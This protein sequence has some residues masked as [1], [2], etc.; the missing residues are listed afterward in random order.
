MSFVVVNADVYG[1]GDR[2]GDVRDLCVGM[3]SSVPIALVPHDEPGGASDPRELAH[4]LMPV[5]DGDCG[6]SLHAAAPAALVRIATQRANVARTWVV[7]ELSEAAVVACQVFDEVWVATEAERVQL[8]VAGVDLERVIVVPT[9]LDLTRWA[10]APCGSGPLTFLTMSSD[11]Q[12]AGAASVLEAF[13]TEFRRRDRVRLVVVLTDTFDREAQQV[14]ADLRRFA[15]SL[16]RDAAVLPDITVVHGCPDAPTLRE[17]YLEAH[18]YVRAPTVSELG[19]D[20][21]QAMALGL[22]VVSTAPGGLA[23]LVTADRAL[24]VPLRQT[25][26]PDLRRLRG[27]LRSLVRPGSTQ[28]RVNAAREHVQAH[29]DRVAIAQVASRRL[30]ALLAGTYVS[31]APLLAAADGDRLTLALADDDPFEVEWRGVFWNPSGYATEAHSFVAGLTALGRPIAARRVSRVELGYREAMNPELRQVLDTALARRPGRPPSVSIINAPGYALHRRSAP[32]YA[33]GRTMFETDGLCPIWVERCNAMDEI[34]VPTDF[35]AHTFRAAGVTTR[36]TVIPDGVDAER[37]RPGLEPLALPEV[38]GKV[39]LGIFQWSAYK[40]WDVLLRAWYAAFRGG[41]EATLVLRT[42]V[43]GVEP[44]ASRRQI[45][46]DIEAFARTE[47]GLRARDL[48]RIVLLT[49]TLTE[50]ELPRLYAAADALVAPSR[51]EGWGLPQIE[52]LASGLPVLATA[53]GGT[54]Q[55]LHPGNSVPVAVDRLVPTGQTAPWYVG[56]KWAE[57]SESSLTD[58]LRKVVDAPQELAALAATGRR[59]IEQRWTWA[60]SVARVDERL[61][62]IE[63]E[64]RS[65]VRP[66]SKGIPVRWEGRLFAHHSLAN[67]NRELVGRLVA[68]PDLD[69][70][71]VVQEQPQQAPT[72]TSFLRSTLPSSLDPAVTV[73]HQWPPDLTPVPT[74]KLVLVQPWEYGGLPDDWVSALTTHVDEAWVYT[75]WL[76][77]CYVRSGVPAEKVHLVPLG[78]DAELFNPAGPTYPLETKATVRLLYVGGLIPRKGTD[79]LLRAFTEEFGADDDVALVVKCFGATTVYAGSPLLTLTRAAATD[80]NGPEVVLVEDDLSPS[81][82]AAL[83]RSCDVLVHP[84]RGEGYGLTIAEGMASGLPVVTTAYGA[85]LDFC[86]ADEALLVPA[87]EVPLPQPHTLPPS[88]TGY[89]WAEP[90]LGA[91]RDALRQMATDVA[92][93]ERLGAAG[94]RAACERLSWDHSAA[95]AAARLRTIAAPERTVFVHDLDLTDARSLEVVARYA[96]SFGPE[97]PTTL[98]LQAPGLS[99]SELDRAAEILQ[100]V[101]ATGTR[102]E[103]DVVLLTHALDPADVASLRVWRVPAQRTGAPDELSDLS[104][105]GW[106][107][108]A[109]LA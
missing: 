13:V 62:E 54:T 32:A 57:P 43:Q 94:R 71:L 16:V 89:W 26:E 58:A 98:V 91:L 101:L 65:R 46:Q 78:V 87:R 8:G 53:W 77:D 31:P 9:G 85:A 20:L 40:G 92:L 18:A 83:Y 81:Q 44:R 5:Q 75:S 88:R 11:A 103:P 60:H 59:E 34:W 42:Y 105:A 69:L 36:I 68:D 104:A 41:D 30:E 4:L 25:G 24:V 97:D 70:D 66:V 35:N 33:I 95:A 6:V 76:R 74:G 2:A 50:A 96:E 67:A 10:P 19:R 15:R 72:A 86:T 12:A 73:R 90:D 39:V 22:P 37:F 55:F 1:G 21:L 17:L 100:G 48:G 63:Q 7:D 61:T 107:R 51:G 106:R 23:E 108:A 82:L 28:A 84:Y 93:R 29:H 64:L 109:C 79:L 80:P 49:D 38:H 47:F 56:Q 45:E 27:H 14:E 99:D 3:S 102:G 52:A